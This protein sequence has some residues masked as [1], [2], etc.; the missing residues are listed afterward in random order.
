MKWIWIILSP[1]LAVVAL[2]AIIGAMPP[3][4]HVASRRA[5][6]RQSPEAVW[7][8]IFGAQDWRPGFKGIEALPDRDG[9]KMWRES[10]G[11]DRP[12]TFE[13]VESDPPR[14]MVSRIADQDLPFGGSW[15]YEIEPL[16]DGA[17]SR[18]TER[19]EVYNPIFRFVSRFVIGHTKSIEDSLRGLG[20]KF[21]EDVQ[22]EE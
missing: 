13:L 10:I 14:R 8:A 15:I 3:V 20:K 1:L 4:N 2:I 11:K 21:G 6:F 7:A 9:H 18:V 19:G 17:V 12:I 5:R 22:I 16:P